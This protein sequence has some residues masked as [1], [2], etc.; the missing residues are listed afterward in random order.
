MFNLNSYKNII[1]DFDGVILDSNNIKK[2]AIYNCVQE[3]ANK[4]KSI[5]FVNFFTQNNGLPREIKIS[6]YF[7]DKIAKKILLK[8]NKRLEIDLKNCV[9]TNGFEYFLNLLNIKPYI[10][11]G[12]DKEEI[13]TFLKEKHLFQRFKNI[14]GSPLTKYENINNSNIKGKTLYIGDSKIDYEIAIHYNY[15]FIFM[16]RYTQFSNWSNF[17]KEKPNIKLIKDFEELNMEIEC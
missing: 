7:E 16:F 15:D 14:M 6:T 3:Y 4:N 8:Y 17:F 12:G 10:L 13:I 5:E 9:F 11:S 2:D 1:L